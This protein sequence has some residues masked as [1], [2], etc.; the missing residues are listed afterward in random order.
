MDLETLLQILNKAICISFSVNT[1]K[2]RHESINPLSS[3][4][5]TLEKENYEFKPAN[6]A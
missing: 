1:V 4:G 3:L 2:E 5:K 6:S